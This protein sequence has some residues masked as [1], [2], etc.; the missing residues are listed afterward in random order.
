MSFA[1]VLAACGGSGV[2]AGTELGIGSEDAGP[3]LAESPDGSSAVVEPPEHIDAATGLPSHDDSGAGSDGASHDAGDD[4]GAHDGGMVDAG[5][6]AGDVRDASSDAATMDAG[7][8]AGL[9]PPEPECTMPIPRCQGYTRIGNCVDGK[10]TIYTGDESCCVAPFGRFTVTA[11]QGLVVDSTTGLRW[12]RN[13]GTTIPMRTACQSVGGGRT[14][15]VVELETLV[16]GATSSG[17]Q[18]SPSIDQSAF[19]A[20]HASQFSASDGCVDFAIGISSAGLCT[21]ALADF[22]CFVP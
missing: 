8:D 19:P 18:C 4:A 22:L 13:P 3:S 5:H 20:V 9:P 7:V 17:G 6:D 15:T 2:I 14:P 16:I 11:Q 10:W 21:G 1:C 12:Y